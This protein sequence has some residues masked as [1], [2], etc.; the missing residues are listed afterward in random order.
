[1]EKMKQH[2]L[3]FLLDEANDNWWL[4]KNKL[5]EAQDGSIIQTRGTANVNSILKCDNKYIIHYGIH[6]SYLI[7]QSKSFHMEEQSLRYRLELKEGKIINHEELIPTKETLNP[8]TTQINTIKEES[9]RAFNY[10]RAEAVRYA[11]Y[12]W[13][14][15]NPAYRRFE[16]DC[17]NYIS[18]C[19]F[20][21]GAPMRGA[22]NREVGW[23]YQTDNWSFSWSV[24]HSLRW[25]LSGSN[26]G[27]KAS[28]V[29]SAEELM[30]GDVICYDFQGDDRWD[31]NTI[32][33]RKD[34]YG[35]PLV[36]AHTNNSRNRNWTYEDSAAWTPN[37]QY[38]FF[39]IGE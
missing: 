18:Q 10:D 37:I 13:N 11:E 4:R 1:M 6:L 24:A 19:L 3:A 22:P 32:V 12:W 21:G 35:M 5:W 27:L 20:A 31:H 26:Q 8:I 33:V 28:E 23:W 16:D 39:R 14:D 2:W 30:P 29:S 36:N 9:R 25:Y 17:T 7:K 38:K 15:Y 34:M